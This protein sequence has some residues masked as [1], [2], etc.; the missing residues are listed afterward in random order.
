M[1]RDRTLAYASVAFVVSVALHVSDHILLQ[2]RG[3]GALNAET[4][5]G[6]V[7]VVVAA[8][9]TLAVVLA[10][11]PGASALAAGAHPK[12]L[13]VQLGHTSITRR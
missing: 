13:Q 11:H 6:G 10:G 1:S 5:V 3:L 8:L 2:D 4:I 7:L 9:V 12:L